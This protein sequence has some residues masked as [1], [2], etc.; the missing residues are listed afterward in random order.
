MIR[1]TVAELDI[2]ARVAQDYQRFLN[3]AEHLLHSASQLTGDS[4]LLMRRKLED[5][6]AQAKVGLEGL[7]SAAAGQAI[8]SPS[9]SNTR[10]ILWGAGLAVAGAALAAYL[11]TRQS[12]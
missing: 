11:Y 3:E 12:H 1:R 8:Q 5:R 7:R 6:V 10:S 4:A 9:A 2:E